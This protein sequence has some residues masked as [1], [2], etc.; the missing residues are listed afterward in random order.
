MERTETK[1]RREKRREKRLRPSERSRYSRFRENQ[2]PSEQRENFTTRGEKRNRLSTKTTE[3][4]ATQATPTSAAARDD[5]I[6]RCRIMST[7]RL[8]LDRRHQGAQKVSSGIVHISYLV[9]KVYRSSNRVMYSSQLSSHPR[10]KQ[11]DT[12]ERQREKK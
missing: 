6:K 4:K 5:D 3:L 9:H 8:F 2:V 1:A 12:R 10:D 7:R 11:N